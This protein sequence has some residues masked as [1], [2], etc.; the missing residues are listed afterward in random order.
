MDDLLVIHYKLSLKHQ[1]KWM[2]VLVYVKMFFFINIKYFILGI[3]Y[4]K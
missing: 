2:Y 4:F 3:I 1:I